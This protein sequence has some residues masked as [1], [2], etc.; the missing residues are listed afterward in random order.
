MMMMLDV[1][2]WRRLCTD[3]WRLEHLCRLRST[4]WVC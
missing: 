3:K 2:R 1:I 4:R